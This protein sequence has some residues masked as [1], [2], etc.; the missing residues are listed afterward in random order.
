MSCDCTIDYVRI[1]ADRPASL[2]CYYPT[3]IMSED[4][5]IL[6]QQ[7]CELNELPYHS[8]WD[9]VIAYQIEHPTHHIQY[10]T[11]YGR[12]FDLTHQVISHTLDAHL[13]MTIGDTYNPIPTSNIS[14]TGDC[15]VIDHSVAALYPSLSQNTIIIY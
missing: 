9:Q 7:Y 15:V 1:L 5:I 11:P 2:L 8:T 4:P 14:S 13:Y 6:L 12:L 3:Q 10:I